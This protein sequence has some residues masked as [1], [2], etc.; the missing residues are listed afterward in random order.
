MIS[1]YFRILACA[2]A[3]LCLVAAPAQAASAQEAALEAMRGLDAR[4]AAVGHRLAVANRD[5]CR[6]L[7]YLP[8]FAVHDISQYGGGFREAAIRAFGLGSRPAL[9]A[10]PEGTPAE[11][12]G[13]V[14]DD[15]LVRIDGAPV[16]IPDGG[17]F[18]EMERLFDFVDRA[19]AD[20]SGTVEVRRDGRPI[21]VTVAADQGCASRFQ[22]VPSRRE[23]A[24]ADG[25]YVQITTALAALVPDDQQLAAILAHEFAHNVLGHRSR[26]DAADVDRGFFG[27]FGRSA[28]LV[29]E[30][31]VEADRLSV[32]L[33][34]R[35]GYDMT[36]PV[37]FWSDFGGRGLNF[38]G[39][40][41]HP[42]HRRRIAAFEA[43]IEAIRAARAAGAAPVVPFALPPP[44][45]PQP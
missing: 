37:R 32:H 18:A 34:D 30:S 6:R 44:A 28:R 7:R 26:L 12:A 42:N 33:L 15:L 38:L 43:E 29:R 41:T 45:R 16:P 10:V 2:S 35:A 24:L 19:F 5:L 1:R 25:H 21:S 27:N 40:P 17:D 23:N 31:E 8:G 39:S 14:R 22:L 4:V 13:L 3:L 11:R 9:L 20:G 36:A